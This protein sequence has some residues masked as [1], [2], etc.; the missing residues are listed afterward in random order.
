MKVPSLILGG[1]AAA[2]LLAG[3]GLAQTPPTPPQTTTTATPATKPGTLGDRKENQQDRIAQGVQSGQLTAGETKTLE[4]KEAG[5]NAESRTM[6]SEDDGHLTAADRTALN[7]QQ[8]Q[9]SKQI[10]TDKHNAAQQ[11]YGNGRIGQ[12]DENQQDRIAQGIKN[13]KLSPA[14]ASRLEKQQQ[15]TNREVAGMRE[16]NGGK[17]TA[18]DK[19]TINQQQNKNSRKIYRAKHDGRGR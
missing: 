11:H 14:E 16:A 5:I 1:A 12:R 17:L 7:Q 18:Q 3:T 15:G 19:K 10:Y 6:R 2:I 13:G 8:N 9:V 4:N